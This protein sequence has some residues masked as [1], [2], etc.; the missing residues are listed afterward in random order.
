MVRPYS[1]SRIVLSITSVELMLAIWLSL[2]Q[3]VAKGQSN[4][5]FLILNRALTGRTIGVFDCASVSKNAD[6]SRFTA[7]DA[8]LLAEAEY[9]FI[10]AG[11]G[12]G[13]SSAAYGAGWIAYAQGAWT[14][15]AQAFQ[16][17]WSARLQ[18]AAFQLGSALIQAGFYEEGREALRATPE[19]E[20]G[21]RRRSEVCAAQK[22]PERAEELLLLNADIAQTT[23][24]TV[25]AWLLLAQFYA[26]Q[27]RIERAEYAYKRIVQTDPN[28]LDAQLGRIRNTYRQTQ[29]AADAQYKLQLLLPYLELAQNNSAKTRLFQ[30]YQFAGQ[31]ARS[32]KSLNE[33]I[34]WLEKAFALGTTSQTATARSLAWLNQDI[35]EQDR[36]RRWMAQAISLAPYEVINYL[37]YARL[38]GVQKDSDRAITTYQRAINLDPEAVNSYLAFADYLASLQKTELSLA[39]YRQALQLDPTNAQ[40][41]AGLQKLESPKP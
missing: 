5:G 31:L 25:S 14:K 4:I 34:T 13:N 9:Y 18:L 22:Q 36:A 26:N 35:G 19:I 3:F 29:D 8:T 11:A 33:A 40:A 16:Q 39:F 28:N 37:D 24:Q 23:A 2:P 20:F 1:I 15:A 17:S 32:Q 10:L 27:N 12:Q 41:Q 21:L 38:L 7:P 30:A 6:K